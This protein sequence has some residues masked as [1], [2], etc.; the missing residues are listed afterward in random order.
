MLGYIYGFRLV[1]RNDRN[2]AFGWAR[3]KRQI[4]LIY[5]VGFADRRE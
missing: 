4:I 5:G 3:K 2:R 1:G